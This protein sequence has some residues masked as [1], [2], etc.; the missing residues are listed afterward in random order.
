MFEFQVV[1]NTDVKLENAGKV[2]ILCLATS[3]GKYFSMIDSWSKK[4]KEN[5]FDIYVNFKLND[6]NIN[7][8]LFLLSCY[9][10]FYCS[11]IINI[12]NYI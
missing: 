7:I 3:Y 9:F 1:P 5:Y 11:V 4:E 10:Y 8:K 2:A 6:N 12:M